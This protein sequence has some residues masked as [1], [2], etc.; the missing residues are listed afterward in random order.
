MSFECIGEVSP[1]LVTEPEDFG[2]FISQMRLAAERVL[3]AKSFTHHLLTALIDDRLMPLDP[4]SIDVAD[5]AMNGLPT[6]VADLIVNTGMLT[7][8][9]LH[10]LVIPE[11]TLRDRKKHGKSLAQDEADRLLRVIRVIE[12]A[13]AAFESR[14][15][16][17]RWLRKPK[18]RLGGRSP[19]D[20]LGSDAGVTEIINW[21]DR[22]DYGIAA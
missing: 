20:V 4:G 6:D 3:L 2:R 1:F 14:E 10:N 9:E 12:R 5:L 18:R 13:T 17:M 8:D 7:R 19:M 11:R 16:A 15:K 22:I 21:L